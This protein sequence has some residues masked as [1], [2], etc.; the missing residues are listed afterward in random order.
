MSDDLT[1][2]PE[3][4]E[5]SD[6]SAGLPPTEEKVDKPRGRRSK[7]TSP[8]AAAPV[9]AAPKRIRILLEE[10]DNIPPTGLFIGVN[11]RSYLLVPGEE[12]AV[13]PEVVEAL[14]DAVEDIPRVDSSNN[15][16]D[17]R[18]KMRFPF[19]LLV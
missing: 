4:D 12:V 16:V 9:Q 1:L 8:D 10:N 13:P 11:G 14:N 5:S 17:Y 7:P 15:V 18:K 3:D 6:E 2:P 19:R